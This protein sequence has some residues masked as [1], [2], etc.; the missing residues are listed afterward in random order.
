M[1]TDEASHQNYTP[2]LI[3]A[4]NAWGQLTCLDIDTHLPI[5]MHHICQHYYFTTSWGITSTNIR[6]LRQQNLVNLVINFICGIG[7][8][9]T[10][11]LLLIFFIKDFFIFTC[12]DNNF[13]IFTYLDIGLCINDKYTQYF[14]IYSTIMI[15]AVYIQ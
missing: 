6:L 13:M 2:I 11:T 9:D 3:S 1:P 15:H 14:P 7:T 10:S 4:T 8:A 12:I 5:A